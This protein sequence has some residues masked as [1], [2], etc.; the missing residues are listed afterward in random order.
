M[1]NNQLVGSELVSPNIPKRRGRRPKK[2]L[3]HLNTD[4][5]AYESS[6]TMG[7]N[8]D[9]AIILRLNI[10]P[11][12][13]SNSKSN[14]I[15]Q[16]KNIIQQQ[17]QNSNS[18]EKSDKNSDEGMFKNDIPEDSTC[19]RCA[20]NEKTLALIKS[21][22]DKYEKKDKIGKSN[23]IYSNKLN[24]ISL[25]TGKKV[26][27]TKTHIKCWWDGH[28]FNN[29]P[30]VLPELFRKNVYH[31]I[32]C[33]CSLNCALAYNLYYLKDSKIYQ[34][35][36]LVF[37]LYREMYGLTVD[38]AIDIKEA[39]PKEILE[40][41]GGD[42]TI[43]VFRRSFILINKEYIVYMPPIKPMNMIIEERNIE[44]FDEEDKKY[45]LKRSKPLS[46][47]RSLI[48]TMKISMKDGDD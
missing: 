18:E 1:L 23:K 34:R 35:K 26:T 17:T 24:F 14:R 32:G 39:P 37:K 4:N 29:I 3:D 42:M 15:S 7:N 28:N 21:R 19:P 33:F 13:L 20:K 44:P 38:D 16:K 27:L 8:N 2:I 31:V 30:C 45:V 40:D 43:D 12:K 48:R 22:L 25:T 11:A 41:F 5:I 36:S 46:K 47:Q 10:D 9:S 6:A